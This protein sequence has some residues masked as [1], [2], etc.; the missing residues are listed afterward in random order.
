MD[1]YGPRVRQLFAA[2]AH[3][4]TLERAVVTRVDEQGVRIELAAACT[5]GRIDSLRFRAFGCPHVIAA[6]EAFCAGYEGRP[7]ADLEK[8]AAAEIMQTLPVPVEKTG[9][10]LVL[11]DAVRQLGQALGTGKLH[12]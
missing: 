4:G 8:F 5:A 6:C 7:A 3:A 10:I 11:E 2:P 1:P 12:D 9:R